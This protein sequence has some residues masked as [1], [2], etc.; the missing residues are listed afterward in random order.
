MRKFL[1]GCLCALPLL[2]QAYSGAELQE[3]CLA[4]E[5]LLAGQKSADIFHSVK[6]SRCLNYLEGFL[7]GYALGERLSERVGVRLG[8]FCVPRGA[9]ARVRLVRAVLAYLDRQPPLPRDDS[10]AATQVVGAAF[11]K[12]FPCKE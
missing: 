10:I 9:E 6:S 7:D 8:A 12:A 4:A 3:D 1:I 11:S 2:A 5:T